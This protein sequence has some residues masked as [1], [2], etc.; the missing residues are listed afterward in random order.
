MPIANHYPPVHYEEGQL[1][2]SLTLLQLR[3]VDNG[4]DVI[5]A[6]S[7]RFYHLLLTNPHY[8]QILR[9][10]SAGGGGQ[11]FKVRFTAPNS[12]VIEAVSPGPDCGA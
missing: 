5:F 9:T 4:T 10:L 12:D 2:R 3:R 1:E 11:R 8:D 7:A 6:E